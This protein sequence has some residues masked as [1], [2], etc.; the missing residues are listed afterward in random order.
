MDYLISYVLTMEQNFASVYLY[1]SYLKI[2]VVIPA[3]PLG[4]KS[5]LLRITEQ[6]GTLFL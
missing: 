3:E 4:G 2:D 5:H 1:R 6:R